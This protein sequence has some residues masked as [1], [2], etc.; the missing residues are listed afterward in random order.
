MMVFQTTSSAVNQLEFTNGATGDAVIIKSTGGDSNIDINLITAGSG[1]INIATGELSYAGA[2]VTSTGAELNYVDITTLGTSEAS[3]AVT[4]NGSGDLIIPDSDKFKFGAGSDMQLYH[5][6][7][8][9]Y[10]TNATGDLNVA[11]ASSGV[12]VK[13]GHGTSEVT[14]GD[15]LVVTGNATIP[16]G[17]LVLNSTAVTSTGTELNLLDGVSGL[18]QADLT[19]LAAVDATAAE[20]NIMDGGTSATGTTVADADRV[21]LN[22]GGTMVQ[23]AGNRFRYVCIGNNKDFNKQNINGSKVCGWWIYCRWKW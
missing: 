9:S 2:A 23:A 1:K 13:I 7:T 6:G 10:I 3:K 16:D 14:V 19:K 5:D 17:G 4:V 22:D 8:D 20:L 11:T 21:V 15:N 12:A 18:V